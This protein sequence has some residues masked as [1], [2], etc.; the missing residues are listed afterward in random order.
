MQIVKKE[1]KEEE[2]KEWEE[3]QSVQILCGQI[4]QEKAQKCDRGDAHET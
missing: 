1:K 4:Q 3:P 2:D